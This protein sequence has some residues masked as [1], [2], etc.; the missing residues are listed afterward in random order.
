[1]ATVFSQ[2]GTA[3][4]PIDKDNLSLVP[5]L[6]AANYIMKVNPM[7]RQLYLDRVQDFTIPKKVYGDVESKADRILKT[8]ADRPATTGVL[9]EGEKGSGKSM[10]AKLISLKAAEQGIPTLII[11]SPEGGDQFFQFIQSINTPLVI[12]FDEFEKVFNSDQQKIILTLLDGMFPSKTLFVLTCNDR[13]R[14]DSHMFNRPGRLYYSVTYGGLDEN[15]IREYANDVLT[16]NTEEKIN[17]LVAVASVFASFNFD[18]LQAI[19]EEM[20]RYNE[21]PREA[22]GM[23]NVNPSMNNTVEYELTELVFDGVVIDPTKF[24]SDMKEVRYDPSSPDHAGNVRIEFLGP[25]MFVNDT[26]DMSTSTS[27]TV[28]DFNRDEPAISKNAKKEMWYYVD[29]TYADLIEHNPTK[30]RYVYKI[31]NNVT[32]FKDL[33]ATIRRKQER[34]YDRW[35]HLA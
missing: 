11:N 30:G 16:D 20:N 19:V 8:F 17:D 18:M 15:F 14:I 24:D 13:Y 35:S 29:M 2:N 22:L 9:L 27:G 32:H 7:T 28:L 4:T 12:Q 23:L 26:A 34:K 10:L 25:N 6:P 31:N 3:F 5:T 21:S 33:T 1:M